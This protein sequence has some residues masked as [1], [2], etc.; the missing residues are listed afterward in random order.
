MQGETGER[1]WEIRIGCRNGVSGIAR[2]GVLTSSRQVGEPRLRCFESLAGRAEFGL[3]MCSFC[4]EESD[5]MAAGWAGV[6]GLAV[7]VCWSNP[8]G[9]LMTA[10]CK[11]G[12]RAASTRSTKATGRQEGFNSTAVRMDGLFGA[13]VVRIS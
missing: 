3:A 6:D 12:R 8:P 13:A 7:S 1:E 10:E 5:V 2:N 9:G 4:E 11:D